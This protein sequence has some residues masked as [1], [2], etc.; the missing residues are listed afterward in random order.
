M[1]MRRA[2]LKGL[3][4]IRPPRPKRQT[5]TEADLVDRSFTRTGRDQL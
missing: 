4:G 3:P 2:G 1:L 5:P